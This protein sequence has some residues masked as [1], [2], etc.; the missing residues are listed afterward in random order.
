MLEFIL[1]F[2]VAVFAISYFKS[3]SRA[4]KETQAAIARDVAVTSAF[5]TGKFIKDTTIMVVNG[6]EL[7]AKYVQANHDEVI[8][9]AKSSIDKAKAEH[10]GSA[11]KL[12]IHYGESASEWCGIQTL[13]KEFKDAISNIEIR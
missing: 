9:S 6:G 3:L 8:N 10:G 2:V 7:T 11:K 1:L 5:A 13:N 12:G 4:Q